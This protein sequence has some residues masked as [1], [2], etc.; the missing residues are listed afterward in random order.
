MSNPGKTPRNGKGDEA[1][2]QIADDAHRDVGPKE[3]KKGNPQQM[4]KSRSSPHRQRCRAHGNMGAWC[5]EQAERVLGLSTAGCTALP[6]QH[7]TAQL[8]DGCRIPQSQR[9]H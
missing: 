5:A 3:K 4:G 9:L 2:S 6:A 8:S 7:S 1:F